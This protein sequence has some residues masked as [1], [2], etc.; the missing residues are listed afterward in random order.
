MGTKL[1]LCRTWLP[2]RHHVAARS[3]TAEGDPS[4][5]GLLSWFWYT[6]VLSTIHRVD[7]ERQERTQ[8]I[9]S[10]FSSEGTPVL[11]QLTDKLYMNVIETRWG[12][13]HRLNDDRV[14]MVPTNI[15]FLL[16]A[17]PY[18]KHFK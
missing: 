9:I 17:K 13:D 16:C 12:G 11:V 4:D 8:G 14:I 2:Q 5:S 10:D 15:E 1:R 7:V 18:V 6:R 3:Y